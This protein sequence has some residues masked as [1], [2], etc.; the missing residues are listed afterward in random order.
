[1]RLVAMREDRG[2]FAALRESRVLIYWPH[3]LGDWV[4]FGV[5]AP[6]LEPSNTY[7][8][9]RFGDD[10]VSIM[11][12]NQLIEPLTSGVRGPSDGAALGAAHLGLSL[13]RCSGRMCDLEVPAPL[14]AAVTEFAPQGL[15][16]TDYP[17]T[18]GRTAYPFHTKARNL[19][20][21]LV[22]P[23]RLGRL[24]LASPLQNSIDFNAS[25]RTQHGL[26]ARLV[27]FAAPATRLGVISRSGLTAPRKNWGSEAD[28][29]AFVA[30]MRRVDARWRFISMDEDDFGEGT[31][32]FRR[33]FGDL[34]EPFARLY[35]AL[36]RRTDLFVGIP[37]GPLHFVMARGGIPTVGL[38]I[39]HHPDW[40][41]EPNPDAVH[42]IG[43]YVRDRGFERR[44][45]SVTKPP[46]LQH[47]LVYLETETIDAERVVEAAYSV[48]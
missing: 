24:D 5:I 31:V 45:A 40:Y 7:A 2:R 33:L 42:L 13:E 37:A 17:E 19:A 41:D 44:A 10:Y 29:R 47:R 21:F 28:A 35:K 16:W 27:Q 1:M 30:R 48:M 14:D 32:G 12:G 3:G 39:A 23:E 22:R 9:T 6:L 11:E 4:H 38:W 36:A 43:R 46:S 20:R 8:I 15:L 26:D 25:E 34:E 18:E